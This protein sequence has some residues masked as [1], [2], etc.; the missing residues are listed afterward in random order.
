MAFKIFW[1]VFNHPFRYVTDGQIRHIKIS[2][3]IPPFLSRDI[4]LEMGVR[5]VLPIVMVFENAIR[6]NIQMGQMVVILNTKQIVTGLIQNLGIFFSKVAFLLVV[7][8]A[9]LSHR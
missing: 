6:W 9:A 3:I 1:N 7:A 8:Q 5:S 4:A 2:A